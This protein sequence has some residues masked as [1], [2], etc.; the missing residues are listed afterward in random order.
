MKGVL[1]KVASFL[2]KIWVSFNYGY[3]P[4][5]VP[6]THGQGEGYGGDAHRLTPQKTVPLPETKFDPL[7]KE[8]NIFSMATPSLSHKNRRRIESFFFTFL[9]FVL[10]VEEKKTFYPLPTH[11]LNFKNSPPP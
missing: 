11:T 8:K 3:C 1:G 9:I 10:V 7:N 5:W 6:T 4:F 2:Q